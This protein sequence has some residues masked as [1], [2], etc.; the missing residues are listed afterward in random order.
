MKNILNEDNNE[1]FEKNEFLTQFQPLILLL[2][3]NILDYDCNTQIYN[4]LQ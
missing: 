3:S 1:G 4:S 2:D